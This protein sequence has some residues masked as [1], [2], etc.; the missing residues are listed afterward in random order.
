METKTPVR[1]IKG[2]GNINNRTGAEGHG[3]VVMCS[4]S[5]V[6]IK[7]GSSSN[8]TVHPQHDQHHYHHCPHQLQQQRD[9]DVTRVQAT[10]DNN[11][12]NLQGLGHVQPSAPG[13]QTLLRPW[14]ARADPISSSTPQS[15][16]QDGRQRKFAERTRPP[17]FNPNCSTTVDPPYFVEQPVDVKSS[18]LAGADDTH[19]FSHSINSITKEPCDGQDATSPPSYEEIYGHNEGNHHHQ[20]QEQQKDMFQTSSV[21]RTTTDDSAVCSSSLPCV[22]YF[23]NYAGPGVYSQP[24]WFTHPTRI[25]VRDDN[26]SEQPVSPTV[27]VVDRTASTV[28]VF[29]SKGECLSLLAVPRVNGGCF[30]G[31]PPQLLLAVATSVSLYEMD[32]KLVKQIP[33]R[34]RQQDAEVLTTVPHGKTGFIAVRSRSLSICRGGVSGPAV[35]HT[36]AGRYRRDRGTVPFVNVVDVAVDWRRGHLVVLDAEDPSVS[37][38]HTALYVMTEDG[39]V[40]RAIRPARDPNCGPLLHPFGVAVDRAGHVL[41][42]D[43][44]RVVQFSVDDGR[45]LATLIGDHSR[46]SHESQRTDMVQVR[47]VAV[48]T[49]GRQQIL[50]TVLVGERLAQIRAFSLQ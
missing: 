5:D 13:Q 3:R 32:G 38:H 14:T 20:Q 30:I 2:N 43:G 21:T 44:R 24:G 46:T 47:G 28:H 19:L 33:L 45:Y 8:L 50:Y 42:S 48:C 7:L 27:M 6:Q 31:H 15:D 41:V 1:Y 11:E 40:L 18:Q 49:V 26:Q 37:S 34:G 39:T 23:G 17:P 9:A 35:I 25:S 16:G 12:F 22:A 29:T 36:V 10:T 4:G